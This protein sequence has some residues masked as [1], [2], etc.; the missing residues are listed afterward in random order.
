MHGFI[1][2]TAQEPSMNRPVLST[3]ALATALALSSPHAFS[4]EPHGHGHAP[5]ADKAGAVRVPLYDN[6]GTHHY[7]ITTSVPLAQRYFDQGLRLYYAF[8]H[9]E[10][11]RSFEEAARLDP[12]CAM[13]PWGIALALGPNINAPMEDEAA[14]AAHA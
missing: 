3:L 9:Q 1:V 6:L 10:S 13:A 12:T 2:R 8:N 14:R 4:G 7:R 5:A 11:I